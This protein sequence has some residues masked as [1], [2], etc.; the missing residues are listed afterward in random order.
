MADSP[1]NGQASAYTFNNLAHVNSQ[2]GS[3]TVHGGVHNITYYNGTP[4][5][6]PESGSRVSTQEYLNQLQFPDHQTRQRYIAP[7]HRDTCKWLLHDQEFQAWMS[8]K[9]GITPP[10]DLLW[11]KGKPGAGKSTVMRYMLEHL[12]RTVGSQNVASFFFHARGSSLQHSE[13][14]LYR[15]LLLQVL[16]QRSNTQQV[17]ANSPGFWKLPEDQRRQELRVLLRAALPLAGQSPLYILIDALDECSDEFAQSI[18]DL[19]NTD[20][21]QAME[22]S[23]G[24]IRICLASRHYPTVTASGARPI[25]LEQVGQHTADIFRYANSTLG[26]HA[27]S[28]REDIVSRLVRKA[29]G[30]FLWVVLVVQIINRDFNEGNVHKVVARIDEI[31]QE[32]SSLIEDILARVSPSVGNDQSTLALCIQAVL[33]AKRPLDPRELYWMLMTRTDPQ[34][35]PS[36]G[37]DGHHELVTLEVVQR[38]II[39]CSR[40][41]VEIAQ[42]RRVQDPGRAQFIHETVREFFFG[43]GLAKLDYGTQTGTQGAASIMAQQH[44]GRLDLEKA[45]HATLAA[46]C[47]DYLWYSNLPAH[48]GPLWQPCNQP[49]WHHVC[50]LQIMTQYPLL[51]YSVRHLFDHFIKSIHMSPIAFEKTFIK[52]FRLLPWILADILLNS[53][54]RAS[55]PEGRITSHSA[56]FYQSPLYWKETLVAGRAKFFTAQR[57][58]GRKLIG[59]LKQGDFANIDILLQSELETLRLPAQQ[60]SMSIRKIIDYGLLKGIDITGTPAAV[61][62]NEL[63]RVLQ[64]NERKEGPAKPVSGFVNAYFEEPEKH[65]LKRQT[66]FGVSVSR[67]SA[68]W[69]SGSGYRFSR[70]P[71]E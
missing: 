69:T 25:L 63:H 3:Q 64:A 40:G 22:H 32:L 12:S 65:K 50:P 16:Q 23:R 26:L 55:N 8:E 47:Q 15:S 35:L 6:A 56:L 5:P 11:M 1:M 52:D 9:P 17:L 42:E 41:L 60:S 7:Q 20:V 66:M 14:G 61:K 2:I 54:A 71:I 24:R 21:R 53:P 58:L 48:C 67:S 51:E 39:N 10:F 19:L 33:F 38:F 4:T 29:N 59:Y 31:P 46:A 30:V 45:G 57:V 28:Q 37:R 34:T 18:I 44:F 68:T 43:V 70:M 27:S 13:E 62:S 49:V 36:Q